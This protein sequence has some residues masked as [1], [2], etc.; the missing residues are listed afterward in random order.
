MSCLKL[1]DPS[2]YKTKNAVSQLLHILHLLK[3][4]S[5]RHMEVLNQIVFFEVCPLHL[6]GVYF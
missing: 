4:I 1:N 3:P 6:R 5:L 2:D